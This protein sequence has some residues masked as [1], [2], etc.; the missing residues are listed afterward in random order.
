MICP[1]CH[2]QQQTPVGIASDFL[3][4][5]KKFPLMRCSHCGLIMTDKHP[6][7]EE[8]GAYYK[9]PN[10]ISHSDVHKGLMNRLYHTARRCMLKQ[11]G[12]WV[13][14]AVSRC[15]G[16][17]PRLLDVGCGTGYFPY[18]MQQLGYQVSCVEQD[19]E[20]RAFTEKKFALTPSDG[21]LHAHWAEHSFD[22]ITLWHVLEH[23][24]DLEEHM[25]CLA[26]LLPLGGALVVAVPNP[27]SYDAQRLGCDWAAYDVPRHVWHFTPDS[28]TTLAERY[29]FRLESLHPMW[30]DVYYIALMTQQQRGRKGLNAWLRSVTLGLWSNVRT[31]M[32]RRA[33][34]SLVYL[35]RRI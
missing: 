13:E 22:V 32:D 33:A 23:I 14:R 25:Q 31:L 16:Q 24:V 10:Y 26:Q 18:Y 6:P 28:L 5:G 9:N 15:E 30:L 12:R 1:I 3:V 35:F 21:L 2:H 17:S 27:T 29:G 4:S 11:K 20:A 19:A 7:I 8:L 34:S